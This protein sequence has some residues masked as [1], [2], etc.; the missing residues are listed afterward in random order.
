MPFV[1]GKPTA[2]AFEL[3]DVAHTFRRGHRLMV[4]VQS[5]WF[6]LIDRNPQT[7]IDIPKA[8]PEDFKIATQRVYRS[9]A[10]ASSI[11]LPVERR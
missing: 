10:R 8:R 6:P 5:S 9:K 4:Q 1:P 11:T 3:P 2:I 7:F